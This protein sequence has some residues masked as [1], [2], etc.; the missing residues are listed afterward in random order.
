MEQLPSDNRRSTGGVGPSMLEA[1]PASDAEKGA[2]RSRWPYRAEETEV[3]VQGRWLRT[4]RICQGRIWRVRTL[5][6]HPRRS[7]E[8]CRSLSA[9][10]CTGGGARPRGRGQHPPGPGCAG[11]ETSKFQL[12]RVE[13]VTE[14]P[15][16]SVETPERP[17]PRAKPSQGKASKGS[18]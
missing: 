16:H 3:R 8:S 18:Q 4:A 1:V 11:A 5:D 9:L 13:G 15:G 10:C 2:Q 6:V 7:Q 14:H 12:D 17:H